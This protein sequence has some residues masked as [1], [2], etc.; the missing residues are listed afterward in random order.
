M[1]D[2][3]TLK[4]WIIGGT[5]GS[6]KSSIYQNSSELIGSGEFVNADIVARQISPHDT[7]AASMIEDDE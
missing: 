1:T 5:N 7:D 4:C 3:S 2:K 6:G